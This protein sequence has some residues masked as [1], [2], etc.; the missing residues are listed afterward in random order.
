MSRCCQ[1]ACTDVR[2]ACRDGPQ[3]S[4]QRGFKGGLLQHAP[5]ALIDGARRHAPYMPVT[6][7]G[8]IKTH[9]HLADIGHRSA[10]DANTCILLIIHV[11]TPVPPESHACSFCFRSWFMHVCPVEYDVGLRGSANTPSS[12][13][14]GELF[15]YSM[16]VQGN[17]TPVEFC[18]PDLNRIG[19]RQELPVLCAVEVLYCVCH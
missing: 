7:G 17:L 13:L 14:L 5:F 4:E 12:C 1:C 18:C 19:D 15:L 10:N 16:L 2:Y 11:H 3:S 8:S 9:P 6:C